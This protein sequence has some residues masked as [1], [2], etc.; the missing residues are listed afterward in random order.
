VSTPSVGPH[1]TDVFAELV[2]A[3]IDA[4]H[5]ARALELLTRRSASLFRASSAGIIIADPRGGLRVVAASDQSADVAELFQTF[6]G[7]GP[8]VDV[9][10]TGNALTVDLASADA[11]WPAFAPAARAVGIG[12]V[13][14]MPVRLDSVVIGALNLFRS[15]PDG[16]LP[17]HALGQAL[18]G[19]VSIALA[20][21][22]TARRA[23][24]LVERVQ[25]ILNERGRVE[26]VKGI[27]AAHLETSPAEAYAVLANHARCRGITVIQAA[28]DVIREEA[29]PIALIDEWRRHGDPVD[30]GP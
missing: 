23:E 22:S 4:D 6:E 29:D 14:A 8:A 24:R 25:Q 19:L 2:E 26:Q 9:M 7:E 18:C 12:W 13:H 20:Q 10:T 5:L 11:R 21:E 15:G 1:L 17:D 3:I 30:G 28:G 27:L 16:D